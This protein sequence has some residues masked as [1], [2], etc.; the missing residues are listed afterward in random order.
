MEHSI[1]LLVA[2]RLICFSK[3]LF[4]RII[5]GN[6][7]LDSRRCFR[8]L[9]EKPEYLKTGHT[10]KQKPFHSTS[11]W[12]LLVLECK[13]LSE[14]KFR[15]GESVLTLSGELGLAKSF[16]KALPGGPRDREGFLLKNKES[17]TSCFDTL[18]S[19]FLFCL[20]YLYRDSCFVDFE[21][22][23]NARLF[24]TACIKSKS[25]CPQHT[26]QTH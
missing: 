21:I 15:T 10:N 12:D 6:P 5:P 1:F 9:T 7:P 23:N 26:T 4:H 20:A 19:R 8:F 24:Q 16:N 13:S 22:P 25:K 3:I 17:V 2:N 11:H 18:E 14:S